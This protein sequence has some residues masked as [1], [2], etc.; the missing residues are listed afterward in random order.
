MFGVT[1]K[2][3]F[4][5]NSCKFYFLKNKRLKEKY[6]QSILNRC[7]DFCERVSVIEDFDDEMNGRLSSLE[8][9]DPG[10]A[11]LFAAS[12]LYSE[13]IILTGDKRS[14]ESLANFEDKEK[15]KNRIMILEQIIQRYIA[16]K[17]FDVI[18][19]KVIPFKEFDTSIR[20][21]FG[22]GDLSNL[23]NVEIVLISY[24][25]DLRSKTGNLLM[26]S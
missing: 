1:Q 20:A 2:E 16:L 6:P 10:E 11:M 24:I 5:T 4:V 13:S 17:G 14:I 21:I 9:I 7:L 15:F 23:E 25:N 18:K 22:S 19:N 3:L 12:V 26:N 8:D